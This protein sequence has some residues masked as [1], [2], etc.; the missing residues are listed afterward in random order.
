MQSPAE[1]AP[2]ALAASAPAATA[3]PAAPAK[4]VSPLAA[5]PIKPEAHVSAEKV[6]AAV[7]AVQ[8]VSR[9]ERESR[10][11]ASPVRDGWRPSIAGLVIAFLLLAGMIFAVVFIQLPP[12][13]PAAPGSWVSEQG[14][15]ALRPPENWAIVASPEAFDETRKAAGGKAPEWLA[16]QFASEPPT[17]A[18]LK[19]AGEAEPFPA[20]AIRAVPGT[21]T[22]LDSDQQRT[23]AFLFGAG[24]GGLFDAV[25]V[26]EPRPIAVDGLPAALIAAEG[27]R[28]VLVTAAE[29]VYREV[30]G[31]YEVAGRSEEQ[32]AVRKVRFMHY[33]VAGQ[34]HLFQITLAADAAQFHRFEI[35]LQNVLGTFRALTRPPL[36]KPEFRELVLSTVGAFAFIILAYLVLGIGALVR[37]RG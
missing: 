13:V 21:E 35:P 19:V 17:V 11:I 25:D 18:F 32:W 20:L 9:Q 34:G 22:G 30:D 23:A 16:R 8:A 14:G 1:P 37:R 3:A 7:K 26:E 24:L 5:E 2:P 12:K 29:T 28:K 31:A 10:D 27:R 15:F 33:V 4:K 6:A 36:L